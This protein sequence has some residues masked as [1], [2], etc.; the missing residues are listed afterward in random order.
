MKAYCSKWSYVSHI[1]WVNL[2]K[3]IT[4]Y[5]V[6]KSANNSAESNQEGSKLEKLEDNNLAELSL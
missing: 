1:K 2:I 4:H 3:V 5:K 6:S